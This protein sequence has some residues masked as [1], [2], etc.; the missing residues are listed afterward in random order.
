MMA[1]GLGAAWTNGKGHQEDGNERRVPFA[2][3]AVRSLGKGHHRARRGDLVRVDEGSTLLRRP[4]AI[5]FDRMRSAAENDGIIIFPV[6]GY[7]STR[8]QVRP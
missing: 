3:E 1:I 6:G 7:K 5:A 8:Y 2:S 4:A